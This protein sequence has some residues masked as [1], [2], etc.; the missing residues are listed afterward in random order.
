MVE[1]SREQFE[2]VDKAS[3]RV[4]PSDFLRLVALRLAAL[5]EA[6][7]ALLD[8]PSRLGPRE[9]SR[10]P[11]HRSRAAAAVGH[12]PNLRSAPDSHDTRRWRGK[13]GARAAVRSGAGAW[14]GSSCGQGTR[15]SGRG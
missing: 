7:P 3:G 4:A 14:R 11:S 10:R 9:E 13:N 6:T 2:Q 12:P 8:L 1:L 15:P 5:G